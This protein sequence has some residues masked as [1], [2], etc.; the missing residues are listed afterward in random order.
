MQFLTSAD[1]YQDRLT[2]FYYQRAKVFRPV[3]LVDTLDKCTTKG[4]YLT[5]YGDHPDLDWTLFHSYFDTIDTNDKFGFMV[6]C[7]GQDIFVT[8]ALLSARFIPLGTLHKPVDLDQSIRDYEQGHCD[9]SDREW[10][11][12]MA[13]N[14]LLRTTGGHAACVWYALF[15]AYTEGMDLL[16]TEDRRQLTLF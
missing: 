14:N 4:V 7:F 3:A 13:Y 5:P 1:V 15:K 12:K 10:V 8:D 2:G 9:F 16:G 6:G 11:A